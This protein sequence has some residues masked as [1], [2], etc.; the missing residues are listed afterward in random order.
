MERKTIFIITMMLLVFS[1]TAVLVYNTDNSLV[2]AVREVKTNTSTLSADGIFD[3]IEIVDRHY[4]NW[5]GQEVEG[6]TLATLYTNGTAP[7]INDHY[8]GTFSQAKQFPF[9]LYVYQGYNHTRE[10]ISVMGGN[11]TEYFLYPNVT[12]TVSLAN[13]VSMVPYPFVLRIG[14]TV[15]SSI[16]TSFIV[17]VCIV[18]YYLF[19]KI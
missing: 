13:T 9:W 11:N 12:I 17:F 19:K 8:E 1:I 18:L 5:N 15:A 6:N 7:I 14:L 16:L 4:G 2:P 10:R 3:R